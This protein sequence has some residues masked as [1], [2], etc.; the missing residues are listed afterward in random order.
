MYSMGN[1]ISNLPA[2]GGFLQVQIQDDGTQSVVFTPA[3]DSGGKIT[4]AKDKRRTAGIKAM[5]A[6]CRLL[7]RRYPSTVSVP[8]L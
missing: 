5:K 7:L 2:D 8:A 1:L 6:L 3:I 4:L